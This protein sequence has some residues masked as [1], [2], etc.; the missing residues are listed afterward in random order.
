MW[1]KP[2]TQ[3]LA[4]SMVKP[5][6]IA[7]GSGE[8]TASDKE[9]LGGRRIQADREACPKAGRAFHNRKKKLGREEADGQAE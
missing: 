3:A 6:P 9:A 7:V 2:K 4:K 1:T 8:R 5:G